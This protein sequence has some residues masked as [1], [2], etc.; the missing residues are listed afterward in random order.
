MQPKRDYAK[1]LYYK[2]NEVATIVGV[3]D[4]V[5]RY[6]ET[7]FP[8]LKPEKQRG[9]QRRYRQRDIDL[10]L[11]IQNLVHEQNLPINEAVEVLRLEHKSGGRKS[12]GVVRKPRMAEAKQPMAGQ[13]PDSVQSAKAQ[14]QANG[15][16]GAGRNEGAKPMSGGVKS[17]QGELAALLQELEEMKKEYQNG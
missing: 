3:E 1:K 15:N 13:A 10:L 2:I 11:T 6:W 14:Y 5:L 7:R 4:Y 17:G 8:M 16:Q 9:D 12:S